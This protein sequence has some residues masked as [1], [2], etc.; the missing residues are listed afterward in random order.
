VL[1]NVSRSH[2][3]GQAVSRELADTPKQQRLLELNQ[4]NSPQPD[5]TANDAAVNGKGDN[6]CS[7]ICSNTS[8]ISSAFESNLASYAS[9][10]ARSATLRRRLRSTPMPPIPMTLGT[11]GSDLQST[12]P[13]GCFVPSC[14]H[15]S[16]FRQV[17]DKD[18]DLEIPRLNAWSNASMVDSSKAAFDCFHTK[19]S[20][21]RTS[22]EPCG[23]DAS[24]ESGALAR[25]LNMESAQG[26]ATSCAHWQ[27]DPLGMP[28]STGI[29]RASKRGRA[30][31]EASQAQPHSP[32]NALL[33]S[34]RCAK[35]SQSSEDDPALTPPR[36][37]KKPAAAN[38]QHEPDA[39][40]AY[41]TVQQ[42]SCTEHILSKGV[43]CGP[44]TWRS[45][46]P[47]RLVSMPA[48]REAAHVLRSPD[49][50]PYPVRSA[51]PMIDG[52]TSL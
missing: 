17:N 19:D 15:H 43:A 28:G 48:F 38:V 35:S 3:Q 33:T 40:P 13:S 32:S 14:A 46:Q 5:R 1:Q 9:C 52:R 24:A 50:K 11:V 29:V 30:A 12:F 4:R 8:Q 16:M 10:H 44:S 6:V 2:L 36:L 18:A 49:D 23:E 22:S 42:H 41:P 25:L 27:N 21:P 20:Y 31:P 45:N 39:L 47:L 26:P 7:N 34:R 37:T 51:Q